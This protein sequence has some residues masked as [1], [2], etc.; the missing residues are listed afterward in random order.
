[1]SGHHSRLSRQQ[2]QSGRPGSQPKKDS[3]VADWASEGAGEAAA[4]VDAPKS[5][6]LSSHKLYYARHRRFSTGNRRNHSIGGGTWQRPSEPPGAAGSRCTRR[7]ER[8]RS[9]DGDPRP[10]APYCS[11]CSDWVAESRPDDIAL[12]ILARIVIPKLAQT[13]SGGA[14]AA[15]ARARCRGEGLLAG[16]SRNSRRAGTQ[17]FP[18]G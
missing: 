9:G 12:Q 5:I 11:V 13:G 16:R 17:V 3:G 6:F 1:M 10:L 8:S 4:P 2:D 15:V 14:P 18:D 7:P